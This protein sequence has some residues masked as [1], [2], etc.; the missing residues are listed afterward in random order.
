MTADHGGSP[1]DLY[2]LLGVD[3][4]ASRAEITRAWRRRARVEHPDSRPRDAAAPARFRALAEAYRVLGDP[5]RVPVPRRCLAGGWG[6][7]W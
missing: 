2:E 1:P 5:A 3:R 4:E 7:P 6:Q